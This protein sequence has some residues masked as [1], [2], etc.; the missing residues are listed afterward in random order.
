MPQLPSRIAEQRDVFARLDNRDEYIVLAASD[1]RRAVTPQRACPVIG[2]EVFRDNLLDLD[3]A[4]RQARPEH[5]RYQAL[6]GGL[7]PA[8]SLRSRL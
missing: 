7:L 1:N 4:F 2:A 5:L 8:S 3:I 6:S